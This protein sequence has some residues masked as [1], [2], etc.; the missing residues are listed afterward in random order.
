VHWVLGRPG[1]YLNTSG[2]LTLLPKILDAAERF[3]AAPVDDEMQRMVDE[4]TMTP[5]FV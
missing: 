1:V 3:A 5:L 4:R 2:D